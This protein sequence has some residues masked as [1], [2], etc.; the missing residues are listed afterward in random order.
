MN[1]SQFKFNDS[2]MN[3]KFKGIYST[4]I[5]IVTQS[6]INTPE[7]R[8]GWDLLRSYIDAIRYAQMENSEQSPIPAAVEAQ[9]P[10]I[11]G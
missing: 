5:E 6:E 11:A 8:L 2:K 7:W 4:L 10:K 1:L 9:A 3:E